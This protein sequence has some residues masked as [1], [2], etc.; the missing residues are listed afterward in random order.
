MYKTFIGRTRA[1]SWH[2]QN[3]VGEFVSNSEARSKPMPP[4]VLAFSRSDGSNQIRW[5]R[6]VLCISMGDVVVCVI[7]FKASNSWK[8]GQ[9][10][11]FMT[12]ENRMKTITSRTGDGSPVRLPNW[13]L[14]NAQA[15]IGNTRCYG[16]IPQS[17]VFPK[18]K[19]LLV[20]VVLQFTPYPMPLLDSFFFSWINSFL[21]W[22][23]ATNHIS[24]SLTV[25]ESDCTR[26]IRSANALFSG[27]KKLKFVSSVLLSIFRV[28]IFFITN[29]APFMYL[30][31]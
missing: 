17:L 15:V 18:P 6:Y 1:S 13:S 5:M 22:Q 31:F 23:T 2:W 29:V 14:E 25:V 3:M 4:R 27:S 7:L 10:G 11:Q 9:S 21:V 30:S 20:Y 24:A 19:S 12:W 8:R 26:C 16:W 28:N